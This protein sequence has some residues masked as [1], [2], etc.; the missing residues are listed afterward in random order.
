MTLVG[1]LWKAVPL[2]AS[3]EDLRHYY[4]IF[5][6]QTFFCLKRS[7]LAL[8]TW[9]PGCKHASLYRGGIFD[10]M[11][12]AQRLLVPNDSDLIIYAIFGFKILMRCFGVT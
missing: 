5:C 10:C 3:S 8:T 9:L 4:S 1:T 6:S 7:G 2:M 12:T 11:E